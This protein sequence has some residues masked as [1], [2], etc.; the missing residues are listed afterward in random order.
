MPEMLS[1]RMQLP[2]EI[3]DR[4][5]PAL[6]TAHAGVPLVVELFRRMGAAQVVNEQVCIKQRRRG[7]PPAQLIET[8]VALWAAG[9]DRCQDLQTLRADA[10]L[11]T[12]LGYELPAAT[13]MRDFLEGFH[14]EDSPLW[15]AGE[16][17]AVPAEAAPL[18]GVGIANRRVLAAVQQQ[19]P[20]RTATLDVDA[21]LLEAHK[22]TAT[23]A[24][25]GTPGYQPVV[26]VWAE[27]DLIAH[28]EFRDGNVPAG[29]GNVRILERAIASLPPGITQI[30]VRG[31]SALYEQA[32]LAW[33]EQPERGVGYA[34]SAD[35]TPPLRAEIG[36]LP[37][38]AWQP[39]CDEPD[40]IRE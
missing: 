10:A 22:R 16:K 5:D 35:M 31:D 40:A 30:L 15:R 6:I 33:C 23:V 17:T 21:T 4:I 13:T 12:L 14:V 2:F 36:R 34:I 1:E 25:E 20:Q 11:A 18:A 28:D 29:C 37:E 3:D 26:A 7:L 19:A 38:R 39:D 8:L 24:Y 32:L 27:Q 9:G